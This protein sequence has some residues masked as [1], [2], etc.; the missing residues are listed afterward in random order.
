MK[1][2]KKNGNTWIQAYDT[3]LNL[4]LTS[5]IKPG[6]W[7]TEV[8]LSKRLGIGR[9]PIRE[10]LHKLEQE[11]LIVTENRRKRVYL[12]TISEMEEIFDIKICLESQACSWAAARGTQT[13]KKALKNILEDLRGLLAARPSDAEG[14]DVWFK[15]WTAKDDALHQVIFN[16]AGN[17]RAA[18]FINNLNKQW[19]RLRVGIMAMEGRIDK[20][21]NEHELFV[22]AI[23]GGNTEVAG[24]AMRDHLENLKRMLIQLL[25][26]F[27]YPAA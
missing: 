16:M 10:A 12:L 18:N 6:E 27:N 9:T 19:H 20:S 21:L 8:G 4:I 17:K 2:L 15:K 23:I 11:G 7:V 24:Q 13:D 3:V 22:D 25:K 1:N 26:M 5:A 14:E